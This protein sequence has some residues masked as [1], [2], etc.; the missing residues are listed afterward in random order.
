MEIYIAI[1]GLILSFFFAGSESAF[2][3]FN[4]LR[5]EVWKKRGK[6]FTINASFFVKQPENFFSTI[7]MGNNLANI[8]YTTFATVLLIQYLNE[9]LTWAILTAIVLFLG[10]ILPKTLFRSVA[11]RVVLQVLLLVRLFYIM[12]KPFILSINFLVEMF[13]KMIRVEHRDVKSYFSREEMELLLH[14]AYG[15]GSANL[16]QKYISNVLGFYESKVREA[17]T[18]RTALIGCP[19]NAKWT[20]LKD[21]VLDNQK[22]R[23]PIFEESLDNIVG[24]AFMYDIISEQYDSIETVLKPAYFVPENKSCLDLLREFQRQSISTAIVLDEYGGT[25]GIVTSNDLIEELF[26]EFERG[27][28]T[29]PQIKRL[30]NF[31]WLVEGRMDLDDL[32]EKTGIDFPETESETFAGFLLDVLGHIPKIGEEKLFKDFRIEV[33]DATDK[34]I[35]KVKMIVIR[36]E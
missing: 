34:R 23:I 21:L 15:V 11:N 20:E 1:V 14:E 12:L 31:T 25:A 32:A 10:E 9:T 4:K 17:M 3:A 30:N 7:L 29:Q 6:R 24:I 13:L 33:V 36:D 22:T 16:E 18:P 19:K 26:G 35:E 2:T 8:L 28:E 5:L 27:G